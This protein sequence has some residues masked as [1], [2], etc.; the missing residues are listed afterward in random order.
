MDI[1]RFPNSEIQI[2]TV[3]ENNDPDG[4]GR[5]RVQFPWQK[6]LG[7]KTPWLRQ[8]TPH[9]GSDK[10]FHFIPEN[11]E[12]VVL[13]FEGGNAER[14][15]II[16]SLYIGTA[17]PG[18]WKTADNN[19]KA[20]R[21]RSGHTIE[22]NDTKKGEFITIEDT[23]G[24]T[25]KLDTVGKT[26]TIDAPEHIFLNSKNISLKAT[27]NINL[28]SGENYNLKTKELKEQ[29][30]GNA[31]VLVDNNIKEVCKSYEKQAE[32]L[33]IKASSKVDVR[34]PDFNHGV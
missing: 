11:G 10:G 12:E 13:N 26:I 3:V 9:A 21:T 34:T 29:I 17:K 25:I 2:A 27:E 18:S 20:I 4:L 32:E 19:I 30:T 24:N 16:G 22:L 6:P 28:E 1:N 14:P 23:N 31:Q 33:T 15:F 5:V 8:M 7:E